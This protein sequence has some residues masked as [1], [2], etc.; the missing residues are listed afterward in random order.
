MGCTVTTKYRKKNE[1]N[2]ISH[3]DEIKVEPGL[4]IQENKNKFQDIYR[5]AQGLGSGIYDEVKVCYHRETGQ[6]RAVKIFKKD[7]MKSDTDKMTLIREITILRTL[8]HPNI[9]RTFE[10]FEDIKRLY[11]IMEYCSGGELF[12]EILRRQSFSEQDAA[13]IFYQ[14]LSAV[15]YLHVNGITHGDLNPE[16]ILLEERRD[17]LNIKLADFGQS[18]FYN[19]PNMA[20]RALGTYFFYPPECCGDNEEF[21]PKPTDIWALGIT[22]YIILYRKLPFDTDSCV[23]IFDLIK[24]FV[25]EFPEEKVVDPEL[26][27][28]ISRMLD[29]NPETRATVFDLVNDPWINRDSIPL[30]QTHEK[31]EMPTE[32][33]ITGAIR[34]MQNVFLAVRF[35]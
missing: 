15:S 3:V 7:L 24:N 27:R 13:K 30:V 29:K 4:F 2:F 33:E 8:D 5:L 20:N 32:R 14:I 31:I 10:F 6:K 19:D 35:M 23:E 25:L 1:E 11:L 16:N 34:K 17:S 9:I 28:L 21:L 22:F 12:T 18:H 26:K